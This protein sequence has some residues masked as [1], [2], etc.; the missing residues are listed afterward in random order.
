MQ[1][2]VIYVPCIYCP[3][4]I[5]FILLAWKKLFG[6]VLETLIA[7]RRLLLTACC[8]SKEFIMGLS[9]PAGHR[10]RR[11]LSH[12]C[13]QHG[14]KSSQALQFP[15]W[16]LRSGTCLLAQDPSRTSLQ[17]LHKERPLC[18]A[19][20]ARHVTLS[21][22]L[23][24]KLALYQCTGIAIYSFQPSPNKSFFQTM[25]EN[26]DYGVGQSQEKATFLPSQPCYLYYS[27]ISY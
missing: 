17:D 21:T 2:F 24:H 20:P 12:G 27:G 19:R 5:Q 3:K 18:A 22:A 6:R 11:A 8:S 10:P 1:Y 7:D 9:L 15:P 26:T 16:P 4:S 25:T 14:H 13:W 23:K